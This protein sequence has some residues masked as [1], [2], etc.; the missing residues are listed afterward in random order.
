MSINLALLRAVLDAIIPPDADPGATDLGVDDFVLSIL[1]NERAA[2]EPLIRAGLEQ[3]GGDFLAL[4]PQART[5]RLAQL[6][7]EPWFVLL[8]EL[9][10]EGYYADPDNGGNRDARSW[11]MLG[12]E[13]RLPERLLGKRH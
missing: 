12:Y 3:L 8:A 10:A 1:A 13:P 9:A 6:A 2:E 7:A 11:A 5:A 4:D